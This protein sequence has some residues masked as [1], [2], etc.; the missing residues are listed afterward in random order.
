MP[1]YEYDYK[2]EFRHKGE[3]REVGTFV[4]F[5]EL[6]KGLD[7][8][9]GYRKVKRNPSVMAYVANIL[10]ALFARR[11]RVVEIKSGPATSVIHTKTIHKYDPETDGVE[12]SPQ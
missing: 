7:T 5:A 8:T 1:Q 11:M 9:Q 12:G 3:W 10:G 6:F 4:L 2:M